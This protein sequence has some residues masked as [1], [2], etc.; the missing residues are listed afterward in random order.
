MDIQSWIALTFAFI[1]GPVSPGPSLASVLRNTFF[2][3]KMNGIL[4]ASGH[5]LGFGFYS[6][7][8]LL[9]FASIFNFFPVA[10]IYLRYLG[11]LLLISLAYIFAKNAIVHK[12][13][14][15]SNQVESNESLKTIGF[16][17]GF[18]V[19]ILNPK[20][21]AWMIAIYTP[22]INDDINFFLIVSI[23]LLGLII[24]GGWYILVAIFVGNNSD[25]ITTKISSRSIDLVMSILM[26]FFAGLLSV[27][28]I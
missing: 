10:E 23:A 28:M 11:I 9:T 19:A 24:D 15:N 1:L 14:L 13:N 26:I 12:Q 21:L 7:I 20:I 6:F 4:S 25:K 22:F 3:G 8:V 18:F 16:L 5:G 17:Q 2:G 27:Q